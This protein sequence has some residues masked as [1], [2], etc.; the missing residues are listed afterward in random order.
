MREGECEKQRKGKEKEKRERNLPFQN[1]KNPKQL[2]HTTK[3]I[4]R[5]VVNKVMKRERRQ[6]RKEKTE[7][8]GK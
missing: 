3:L 5:F 4:S 8:E 6:K 1:A 2:N 7:N